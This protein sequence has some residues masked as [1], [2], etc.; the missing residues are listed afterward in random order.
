MH[1][2]T[3]LPSVA[4]AIGLEP[5]VASDDVLMFLYIAPES[6]AA[7]FRPVV[8]YGQCRRFVT[9]L[10]A[11]DQCSFDHVDVGLCGDHRRVGVGSSIEMTQSGVKVYISLPTDRMV[12]VMVEN[13]NDT[14]AEISL[15]LI[16]VFVPEFGIWRGL[17]PQIVLP[18]EK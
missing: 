16:P 15:G 3:A 18:P 14:D 2:N 8:P 10:R 5:G 4:S 9:E 1:Q 6:G 7:I 13:Y 12:T 11:C 17:D